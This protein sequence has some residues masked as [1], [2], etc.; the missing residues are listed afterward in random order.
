MTLHWLVVHLVLD[1]KLISLYLRWFNVGANMLYVQCWAAPV[2]C[3]ILS[4]GTDHEIID[5]VPAAR[6]HDH[7]WIVQ[8]I[9]CKTAVG[10]C[11]SWW[12]WARVQV[13]LVATGAAAVVNLSQP[14]WARLQ[15]PVLARLL[16]SCRVAGWQPGPDTRGRTGWY[17]S[18]YS[19]RVIHTRVVN[20]LPVRDT[21]PG[22]LINSTCTTAC[23]C[24][25]AFCVR[26]ILKWK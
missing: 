1:M 5:C 14:A 10:S 2:S 12:R 16:A 26:E 18:G 13:Q 15:V 24:A 4:C 9:G 21:V 23:V 7:S 25:C 22:F 8:G 11:D 3:I 6:Q 20:S 19:H 17:Q